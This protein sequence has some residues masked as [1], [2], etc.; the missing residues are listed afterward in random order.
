MST[1]GVRTGAAAVLG[2]IMAEK[3]HKYMFVPLLRVRANMSACVRT[4]VLQF[5]EE[6]YLL[7]HCSENR[8]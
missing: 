3:T 7:L 8:E 4:G 5:R 6:M 1:V 2:R